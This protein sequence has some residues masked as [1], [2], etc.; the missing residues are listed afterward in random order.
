MLGERPPPTPRA[1]PDGLEEVRSRWQ[2]LIVIA[3][4]LEK[5]REMGSQGKTDRQT[6]QHVPAGR[7]ARFGLPLLHDWGRGDPLTH[8]LG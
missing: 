7:W 1:G 2:G 3:R 4:C 5:P 8:R 6:S